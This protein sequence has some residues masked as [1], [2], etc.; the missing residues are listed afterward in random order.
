MKGEI[1]HPVVYIPVAESRCPSWISS[2]VSFRHEIIRCTPDWHSVLGLPKAG[3]TGAIDE[4]DDVLAH[5]LLMHAPAPIVPDVMGLPLAEL[6]TEVDS[7]DEAIKPVVTFIFLT[8]GWPP[9]RHERGSHRVCLVELR[10]EP[11]RKHQ[12]TTPAISF[13]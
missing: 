5:P 10:A 6:G 11:R 2:P 13:L 8:A 9:V 12:N 1:L 3:V 4:L 7:Q